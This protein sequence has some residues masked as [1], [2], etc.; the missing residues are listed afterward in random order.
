MSSRSSSSSIDQVECECE[1]HKL[2]KLYTSW[3]NDNPR[4][5]FHACR[6][7]K[8]RMSSFCHSIW[9]QSSARAIIPGLLRGKNELEVEVCKL[10]ERAQKLQKKLVLTWVLMF[11]F[12]VGW[13]STSGYGKE[14]DSGY[15][16]LMMLD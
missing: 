4:R 16:K 1:G 3:T 8:V 15:V 9:L 13:I 6:K 10:R 2:A 11:V 7:F 14:S 5:R 12:N